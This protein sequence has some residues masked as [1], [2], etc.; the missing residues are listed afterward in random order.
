M[1]NKKFIDEQVEQ[2]VVEEAQEEKPPT[3]EEEEEE[4]GKFIFI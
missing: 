4:I 3:E 1:F 2:G